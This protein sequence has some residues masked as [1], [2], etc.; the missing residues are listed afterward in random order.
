MKTV[1]SAKRFFDCR[2]EAIKKILKEFHYDKLINDPDAMGNEVPEFAKDE[3]ISWMEQRNSNRYKYAMI[4]INPKEDTDVFRFVKKIQ[5]ASTKTWIK[6]F[7]WCIEWREINK[8]MHCHMK[9]WIEESKNPYRIKGEMY[10]T[11]K[12]MV[13]NKL[14]INI[15]YSNREGC[16]EEYIKG[17]KDGQI[18]DHHQASLIM[19]QKC[20]LNDVY[21]N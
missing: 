17:Y 5:K 18:K 1:L 2:D 19:R 7:M 9:V 13:G 21:R 14:H 10:N 4:T 8:G 20:N 11:F 12:H 6:H 15:R 3:L 16:F